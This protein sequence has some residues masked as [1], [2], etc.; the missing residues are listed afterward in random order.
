MDNYDT[1]LSLLLYVLLFFSWNILLLSLFFSFSFLLLLSFQRIG[2]NWGLLSFHSMFLSFIVYSFCFSCFCFWF[3]NGCMTCIIMSYWSALRTIEN[4]IR[5]HEAGKKSSTFFP[6]PNHVEK[7]E[8][9][10]S[11][12]VCQY[13]VCMALIQWSIYY[14]RLYLIALSA[15]CSDTLI[16]RCPDNSQ[17]QETI[18][19][20]IFRW[21]MFFF[22]IGKL[23]DIEK[24]KEFFI[25]NPI[26]LTQAL[27]MHSN[28]S[29]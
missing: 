15:P 28:S 23:K 24:L 16:H 19:N 25:K 10:C 17:Y 8:C 7:F 1:V 9:W 11:L 3:L 5:K 18:F 26:Q 27:A 29:Q 4:W 13:T 6:V 14:Y 20:T 2:S 22:H 12:P 21:R